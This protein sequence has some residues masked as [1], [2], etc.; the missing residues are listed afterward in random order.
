M[1]DQCDVRLG[2]GNTDQGKTSVH[3]Y[4]IQE[5]LVTL[6]QSARFNLSTIQVEEQTSARAGPLLML[7]YTDALRFGTDRESD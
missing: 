2:V 3:L 4:L 5:A 6:V 7:T 1:C